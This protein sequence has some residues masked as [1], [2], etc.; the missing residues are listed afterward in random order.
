[1]KR[2]GMRHLCSVAAIAMFVAFAA[3]SSERK[4]D[5]RARAAAQAVPNAPRPRMRPPAEEVRMTAAG[6]FTSGYAKAH[7]RQLDARAFAA[8]AGCSVLMVEI[9]NAALDDAEIEAV[10]YGTGRYRDR[11]GG[12]AH[13]Y[14]QR[15]FRGVVYRDAAK[16]VWAFGDVAP[17]EVPSLAA[18]R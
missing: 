10:H 16:Q 6:L 2:H 3:A 8:G 18:C 17:E 14:R 12:V 13:F 15:S 7:L 9:T 1:M 4:S 11:E 5:A